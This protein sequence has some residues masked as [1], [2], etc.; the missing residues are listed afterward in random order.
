MLMWHLP[1]QQV[2]RSL[3]WCVVLRPWASCCVK[4]QLLAFHI[5]HIRI[6]FTLVGGAVNLQPFLLARRSKQPLFTTAPEHSWSRRIRCAN[7]PEEW[8]FRHYATMRTTQAQRPAME[9]WGTQGIVSNTTI[10]SSEPG[11]TGIIS[12][13][14][15]TNLKLWTESF[16]VSQEMQQESPE[17]LVAQL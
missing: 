9:S 17:T 11:A 16:A 6:L 14:T 7:W 4:T 15:K 8:L 5:S 1:F 13:R 3:T 10:G 2:C 12:R